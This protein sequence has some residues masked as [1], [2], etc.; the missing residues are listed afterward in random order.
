[1]KTSPRRRCLKIADMAA[2][3][4]TYTTKELSRRTWPDFERLFSQGNG[5]D[6]CWCM[7]FHRPRGLPRAKW[8]PTR[9]QRGKRNRREKRALVDRGYAH[10]I[11]VYAK[12]EPIGWCQYGPQSELPRI[13]NIR[14][15]RRLAPGHGSQ[16]LWRITCFAVLKPYRKRGVAGAALRAALESIQ[17]QGGGLVEAYPI[18]RWESRA[19]GNESTHGTASMF[20]KVGF[21][22]VAPLGSTRFSSHVLMRRTV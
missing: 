9:A 8:L 21:K 20:E 17:K 4:S 16:R 7:H 22:S 10:G 19:F 5:W 18:T 11:L 14:S 3:T 1:M 12:G 15:Y 6:H 13:D 2:K